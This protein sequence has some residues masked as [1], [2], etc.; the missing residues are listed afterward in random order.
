MT[1]KIGLLGIGK[2][3]RD[4]HSPAVRAD[5]RFQLVACASRNAK[6]DGIAN[7]PDVIGERNAALVD[8]KGM[9]GRA[10]PQA[11]VGERIA[12]AD[13]HGLGLG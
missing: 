5:E 8:G 9:P 2:I 4:Q 6:V 7:Y 12:A 3:A 1:V 11:G 13:R 10:C